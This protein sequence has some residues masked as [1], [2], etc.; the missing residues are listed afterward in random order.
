MWGVWIREC[1]IRKNM[2][3]AIYGIMVFPSPCG[4]WVVSK[5]KTVGKMLDE[6]MFPSP[7]GA[8]AVS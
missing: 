1:I 2:L 8:W 4:A 7:Y 6:K 3:N 5:A